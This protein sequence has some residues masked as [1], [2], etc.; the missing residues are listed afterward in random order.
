MIHVKF[1]GSSQVYDAS[2]TFIVIRP[3][4]REIAFFG[5]INNSWEA[6]RCNSYL[7]LVS[8]LFLVASPTTYPPPAKTSIIFIS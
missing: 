2:I 4:L 3:T 1:S 8:N 5:L 6:E 7:I